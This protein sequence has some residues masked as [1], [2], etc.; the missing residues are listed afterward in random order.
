L[1]FMK[2]S[3]PTSSYKGRRNYKNLA[4]KQ[5]FYSGNRRMDP[6]HAHD[7]G[8]QPKRTDV[9]GGPS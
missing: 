3:F 5:G 9:S 8:K 1:S 7:E 2:T 6:P 4:E